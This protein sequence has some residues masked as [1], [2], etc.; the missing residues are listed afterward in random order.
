MKL[1]KY[2]RN[3]RIKMWKRNGLEV[4]ENFNLERGA[5]IDSS[6]PWLIKIGNNVT[7]APEAL[8]LSHDGSTK[9]VIGYSKIGNV[10]IGDNVFIG[11]KTV[12][13]PNTEIG[14]NVI[15]GASSVVS[16]RFPDGVV[17]AGNPARILCSTENFR[18]KHE[19][20]CN[21]KSK[22]GKEYLRKT[23]TSERKEEM[24]NKLKDE[25][26]GYII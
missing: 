15:I 2:I 23:I 13:L 8:V 11:A 10:T 24:K 25:C 18:N 19:E 1:F 4:G 17:I 26:G 5:Y 20:L 6:F 9:K 3:T 7:I 14:N 16:G 12:I 22:Y 21:K